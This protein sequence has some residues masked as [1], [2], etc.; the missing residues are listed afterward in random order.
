ML[1]DGK[2]STPEAVE[3]VRLM[4]EEFGCR[5]VLLSNSSRRSGGAMGKIAGLGY[6]QEWFQGI[7]TSG[8]LTWRRLEGRPDDFWRGLGTRC[9]HFNWADRGAISLEGLGLTA[10]Q[11][12]EEAEFILAHGTE[13]LGGAEPR[14]LDID[15]FLDILARCSRVEGRRIPMV[16]ANPDVVTVDGDGLAK[17]PG[18]LGQA[19][20]AWGGE[21]VNMGKPA[22]VIYDE[23]LALLDMG[24]GEVLAVGDS[25]E[26]D[27]AG[28]QARGIHT[29]FVA[30]GIHRAE[31]VGRDGELRLDEIQ[32]LARQLGCQR[33]PTYACVA[34]AP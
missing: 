11:E 13:C 26:H 6:R 31:T 1:H 27:I 33:P 3:A 20:A 9:L 25:I 34:L 5:V 10:V 14:T 17:M 24:P 32:N 4:A 16:V 19:Y 12:P 29:L 22:G 8:E 21:V 2:V 15:G 30:S 18:Y 28:A 7:V 23:A